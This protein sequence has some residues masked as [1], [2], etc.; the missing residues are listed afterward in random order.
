MLL[1]HIR[2][3]LAVAEQK[4]FTRAAE[5]L[6]VSQPTLSQQIRQLEDT[7]GTQLFDRSGRTV[8]LTDAGEAW[9]RYAKLA[10]QDLDAGVRAIHDVAELSR[11][12][13]RFAVTPTYTASLV[14]PVVDGFHQM[15][16]GIRIDIRELT[17][18]Q[19]EAQLAD[20]RLDIG[21]A[22]HPAFSVD[23]ESQPLFAE[24]LSMVVGR[25]HPRAARRKALAGPDFGKEPL[26]LLNDTF[27]TRRFID[28]H[29][30]RHAIRPLVAI[31]VDTI[32][33]IVEIVRRGQL[34]TVLPDHI[35][36][37]QEGLHPVPLDPPVP[38]RTAAVLERKGA[39]RTAASRAFLQLL[40]ERFGK[41]T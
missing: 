17:Q 9:M 38:T 27:A 11:G 33:A 16:P 7:L 6:H 2:Y 31:E 22:F 4:N 39:Y 26:V 1:R 24:T 19:M 28:E 35:A 8:Q 14:G 32:G 41:P 30:A 34:A 40:T 37:V 36:R 5:A 21:V 10:L 29:F 13:L 12:S 23:I 3:F 20:D 15:H 18:D 25:N